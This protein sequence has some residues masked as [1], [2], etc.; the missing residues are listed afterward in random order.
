MK[1]DSINTITELKVS[2]SPDYLSNP[3][4]RCGKESGSA[5]VWRYPGLDHNTFYASAFYVHKTQRTLAAPTLTSH[6][7]TDE[8]TR[9]FLDRLADCFAWTKRPKETAEHVT[10]T[11]LRKD[12]QAQTTTV[13]I[14]KNVLHPPLEER[15]AEKFF[16][17][18]NA[19]RKTATSNDLGVTGGNVVLEFWNFLVNSN[20]H[21]LEHYIKQV[22]ET[23]TAYDNKRRRQPD[24]YHLNEVIHQCNAYDFEAAS[25]EQL[26][27]CAISALEARRDPFFDSLR[28]EQDFHRKQGAS[29]YRF[30]DYIYGKGYQERLLEAVEFLGRLRSSYEFFI[31]FRDAKNGTRFRYKVISRDY[32]KWD[33]VAY[34]R[35]LATWTN[36]APGIN[37]VEDSIQDVVNK[38]GDRGSV[39]C[40]IQLICHFVKHDAALPDYIGCSKKACALCQHVLVS[41][42]IHTNGQHNFIY[43]RWSLPAMDFEESE[44]LVAAGLMSAQASM[45]SVLHN[46]VRSGKYLGRDPGLMH[47]SARITRRVSFH[48]HQETYHDESNHGR[49]SNRET[50][51][52]TVPGRQS[53]GSIPAIHFPRGV[54]SRPRVVRMHLYECN[55]KDLF[56]I[57]MASFKFSQKLAVT[58]I[59]L[60]DRFIK[61]KTARKLDEFEKCQWL[62]RGF[63]M[64]NPSVPWIIMFRISKDFEKNCCFESFID[65][66]TEARFAGIPSY[67]SH[68]LQSKIDCLRGEVFLLPGRLSQGF[69]DITFDLEKVLQLINWADFLLSDREDYVKQV[70]LH[71]KNI[72]QYGNRRAT[73]AGQ[74]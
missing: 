40:E 27:A 21:R 32:A 58:A 53:L 55:E 59:Q 20:K 51:I 47:T 6:P 72:V 54:Q 1:S 33:G 62:A 18:L 60:R 69:L 9:I 8:V 44:H 67:P 15:F 68:L 31:K 70:A 73:L 26:S 74:L 63:W 17:W 10:A 66:N 46:G 43:P 16:S 24:L 49:A 48:Q 41:C 23:S 45:L 29:R 42:N 65:R 25:V 13:L 61:G 2:E 19:P 5:E 11:A 64:A 57:Q 4:D 28:N 14:A 50:E 22:R 30:P 34:K 39:H 52:Y 56:E 12:E 35:K 37:Q 7:E 3:R 36:F 38:H 71:W